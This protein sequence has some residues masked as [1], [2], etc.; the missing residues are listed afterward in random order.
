MISSDDGVYL[1]KGDNNDVHDRG[2]YDRGQKWLT[3]NDLVGLVR[4]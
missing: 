3:K 2:L 4:G 1:T